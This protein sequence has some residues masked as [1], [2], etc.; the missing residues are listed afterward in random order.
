MKLLLV[1]YIN[2]TAGLFLALALIVLPTQV[3]KNLPH[4][5]F[6][7]RKGTFSTCKFGCSH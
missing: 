6:G 4:V 2:F 3:I 7:G 5:V 1:S